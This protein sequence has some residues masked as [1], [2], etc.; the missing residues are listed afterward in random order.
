LNDATHQLSRRR[1]GL[2]G[3]I[4]KLGG[5]IVDWN[6]PNHKKAEVRKNLSFDSLILQ[7]DSRL[8]MLVNAIFASSAQAP[9]NSAVPSK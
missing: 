7:S 5:K 9:K 6:E 4:E 3:H 1:R 2:I 8:K